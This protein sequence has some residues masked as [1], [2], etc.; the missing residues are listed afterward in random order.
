MYLFFCFLSLGLFWIQSLF[1]A[2]GE[3]DSNF[4][5]VLLVINI[6]FLL[7]FSLSVYVKGRVL[8][9]LAKAI[10]CFLVFEVVYSFANIEMLTSYLPTIFLVFLSFFIAFDIGIKGFSEQWLGVLSA[11]LLVV[12]IPQ[13]FIFNGSR[14][15]GEANLHQYSNNF[16][17]LFLLLVPIFLFFKNRIVQLAFM[18]VSS[19][20]C[21]MCFK[22]G[23][24]LILA[25]VVGI[26]LYSVLNSRVKHKWIF[27]GGMLWPISCV[28]GA[29]LME[30]AEVIFYRFQTISEGSGRAEMYSLI[31]NGAF[32]SPLSFL[33]GHGFFTT[34]DLFYEKLGIALMAHSDYFQVL[35]DGGILGCFMYG[36]LMIGGI[37]I[38]KDVKSTVPEYY[39]VTFIL[40]FVWFSKALISGVMV[41]KPC[42]I[43]FLGLGYVSGVVAQ[44][45]LSMLMMKIK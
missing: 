16:G 23:A 20:F 45:R 22:R 27:I 40:I 18:L 15:V 39:W 1:L 28:V 38:L 35:Y 37:K 21:I 7:G 32:E 44:K 8:P 17:Y 9:F 19:G 31:F 26:Y 5:R 13:Y 33:I 3:M 14:V 43:I 34:Y 4:R 6:L 12:Y 41:D 11:S 2:F 24:I 10:V 29:Y 25:G 36:L 42:A 30:N